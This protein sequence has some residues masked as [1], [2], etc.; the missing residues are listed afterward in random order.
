[1]IIM[2]KIKDYE[3]MYYRKGIVVAYVKFEEDAI[4]CKLKELSTNLFDSYKSLKDIEETIALSPFS[5]PFQ[6][7]MEKIEI[8]DNIDWQNKNMVTAGELKYSKFMKMSGTIDGVEKTSEIWAQRIDRPGSIDLIICD[9]EVVGFIHTNHRESVFLLRPG[10]EEL[11]PL[12][13]WFDPLLSKSG[14][15]VKK[16]GTYMVAMR[17]GI[18]LSTDVWIPS[19]CE[20]GEKLPVLF[21]RTPYNKSKTEERE[22]IYCDRGYAVVVQDVRGRDASE[23]EFLAM[24]YE[25]NDGSDSLDWIAEQPWSNGDIGT[26]GGSYSGYVQWMMAASGNPH[27][28]AIISGVTSGSPFIDIERRGGGYHMG[29]MDWNIT[30]SK[31][32]V[33]LAILKKIDMKDILKTKPIKDIPLKITGQSLKFWDDYM[34][35][36][37][38]DE[39]WEEM[40][41]SAFSDK[42]NVPALVISGWHDG[43]INGST[44]VWEMNK[45]NKRQ[46]Q[47]LIM[48]PWEHLLNSKRMVGDYEFGDN[49]ILYDMDLINLKWLD[50]FLKHI[51]NGVENTRVKYYVEELNEWLIDSEWPPATAHKSILYLNG[52]ADSDADGCV[53]NAL[54]ERSDFAQEGSE[55]D[56]FTYDPSN[57]VPQ[58]YDS[59]SG[60]PFVPVDYSELE[61]RPDVIVYTSKPFEQDT[62]VTGQ[63][64][65]E[66]YAASSALDTDWVARL[67]RVAT[68]GNSYRISDA[69]IRAKYRNS[70]SKPELLEPGKVEKYTIKMPYCAQLI[71][72]GECIRLQ[73]TSSQDGEMFP[74]SNTGKDPAIDAEFV[75]AEQKIY[76]SKQ[77]MSR[78]ELNLSTINCI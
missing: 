78:L 67:T 21:I 49:A 50:R 18:R 74:N 69:S 37:D 19:D 31:Q 39:F 52:A 58:L 15:G 77:Y 76:H 9:N 34:A 45:N 35:H 44:E 75:Y 64:V 66:L 33:D 36:P 30:M 4:L 7:V 24:Y 48:G 61:E 5:M 1:M 71:R 20:Q 55:Y 22:V 25:K 73:M 2:G 56:S 72:K 14:R 47:R 17:D 40:S 46:N 29:I 68:N 54:V 23:G 6:S 11:S 62:I 3:W 60:K 53:E 59:K 8:L 63:S 32:T 28:K 13:E 26:M 51:E 42:I 70:F 27:L 10:Y 12:R 38:Y 41:I 57:P 43:D 65:L 16:L